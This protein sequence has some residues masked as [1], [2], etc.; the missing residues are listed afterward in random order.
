MG[1]AVN[2]HSVVIGD[3]LVVETFLMALLGGLLLD[4][5]VQHCGLLL[6]LAHPVLLIGAGAVLLL[7]IHEYGQTVAGKAR[8]AHVRAPGQGKAVLESIVQNLDEFIQRQV[9]GAVPSPV[10][11]DF[12]R[13]TGIERMV[14]EGGNGHII[15]RIELEGIPV[16]G[17]GVA[18]AVHFEALRALAQEGVANRAHTL[19]PIWREGSGRILHDC[20]HIGLCGG[21]ELSVHRLLVEARHSSL[22]HKPPVAY[23]VEHVIGLAARREVEMAVETYIFLGTLL[24]GLGHYEHL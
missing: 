21:V 2:L 17:R 13:E 1:D 14:G 15:V 22:R 3:G 10:V 11:T 23:D 7:H 24:I 18:A 9:P 12:Q 4:Y 6:G 16:L 19:L 20:L 8:I 5:A